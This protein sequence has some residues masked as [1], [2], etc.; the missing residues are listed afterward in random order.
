ML[1]SSP[2]FCVLKGLFD[3]VICESG[4]SVSH[5][6]IATKEDSLPP[7]KRAQLLGKRVGCPATEHSSKLVDC[8]KSKTA[9]VLV[10]AG[11]KIPVRLI[12]Q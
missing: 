5:W 8:L 1:D 7:K 2:M 9:D 6:A 12:Y 3:A 11:Q 4:V 10:K